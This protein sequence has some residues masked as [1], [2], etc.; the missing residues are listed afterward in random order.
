MKRALIIGASGQDG[1]LL[2]QSLQRDGYSVTGLGRKDIDLADRAA[3]MRVVER[4]RPDEAYYVAAHHH[5]ADDDLGDCAE[6]LAKSFEVNVGGL[7]AVLEGI[8]RNSPSTRLFYCASAHVFGQP[9]D[10]P[11]T[12]RTPINPTC[13]YGITKASGLQC[14]RFYRQNSGVFA[15]VGILFNHD[16]PLRRATA[17]SQKI[18]RGVADILAGRKEHLILG[19]TAARID[20]GHAPDA[21]RAMRSILALPEPDDFVIATGQTHSIQEFVEIAF[22]HAGL[23]WRRHIR[24]NPAILTKQHRTLIGDPSKLRA[25]ANWTNT[26]SFE[27]MVVEMLHAQLDAPPD[28]HLRSDLQRG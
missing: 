10:S 4:E 28:S 7:I 14:C 15:S 22:R 26:V 23:D 24:E 17:V 18:V 20:W 27:D 8:R 21:V 16:S 25:A 3:V 19:N 9:A 12:E 13:A 1:Q 11:L 5:S 6:L 2:T